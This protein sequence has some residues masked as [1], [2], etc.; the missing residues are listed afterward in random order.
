M[1][2]IAASLVGTHDFS[3]FSKE[4]R[5]N[6]GRICTVTASEWYRYD[7]YLVYQISANRFLRS[8]VRY[9]VDTM[10]C[11]G[12]GTLSAEEFQRIL[13]SRVISH[14]LKPALASGLFLWK[15]TY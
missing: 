9:L 14:S 1:Q 3:A 4:D 7:R 13:D 15:V 12:K 10:I 6:P 5:D 11:A 8:M 2:Q